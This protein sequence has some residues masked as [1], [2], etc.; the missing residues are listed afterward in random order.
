M[1]ALLHALTWAAR[2]R[3]LWALLL[4]LALG[5]ALI[6]LSGASPWQAYRALFA[7]AFLDYWGFAS[8]LVKTS[9][10]LLA[11]LAVAVP[12]RA[13]LFNIGAEGQIYAGA[14]LATL[15]GLYLPQL[16][17]GLGLAAVMLAAMAGGALWAAIPGYLKA[18]RGVN[19]VIVTL[20]M[21]FVAIQMVSY[22]V[23]GPLLAQGAPYPYSEELSE[24][25]R[26]PIILPQTD[27]HAGVL[28]G[29]GLALA[30]H[31][32]FRYTA[33]GHALDLVGRNAQA[34][35][36]AG[37][38]VKRQLL[39]AMMG[40]GAL[41]GLAGGLEVLGL[42]YRLFHLFSPGYGFDGIV[43]AFM[44]A[45]NMAWLPVAALLMSGLK[46][47][48]N[49]MQRAAGIEGTVV[50]AI[51]GLI[52]I[53]VAASQRFSVQRLRA[54]LGLSKLKQKAFLPASTPSATPTREIA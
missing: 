24:T 22:A 52:V 33:H 34:A 53:F 29:L 13:G 23:S 48:A 26:L 17:A 4:A 47:A 20:L 50:D 43:V 32:H 37:V 7:G 19:E 42:K 35:L 1:S 45:A 6:A 54:G 38:A 5:A 16:P 49:G 3:T 28:L 10:I 9:P 44:A 12:L 2:L 11:A 36:Y 15:A 39:V 31:L 8:T 25:L 18:Y 40:G 14:L 41:A 27:A 46:A 51:Q 21:N 30:L